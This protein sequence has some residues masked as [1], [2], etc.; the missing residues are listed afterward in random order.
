M[1]TAVRRILQSQ[2]T[3]ANH[4]DDEE[5]HLEKQPHPLASHTMPAPSQAAKSVRRQSS[6]KKKRPSS[7]SSA[8][9]PPTPHEQTAS[10]ESIARPLRDT[11]QAGP[12]PS[13][14]S[15]FSTDQGHPS[16]RIFTPPKPPPALL[17]EILSAPP[18]SYTAA[19]SKPSALGHSKRRFCEICGYWGRVKCVRCGARV[20]GLECK[21]V[22][23]EQRCL[24]FYA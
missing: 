20:C 1:T 19:R 12:T 15:E 4:L 11:T 17:D 8:M 9:I 22:H 16:L 24:R 23:D 2:K 5:A 14:G 13:H 6:T 7:S 18:L 3:F 10:T 21:G